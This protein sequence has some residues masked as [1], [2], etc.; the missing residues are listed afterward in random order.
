MDRAN[1][2][3][4][5]PKELQEGKNTNVPPM[6]TTRIC[7]SICAAYIY[8]FI[9]FIYLLAETLIPTESFILYILFEN[10]ANFETYRHRSPCPNCQ[11]A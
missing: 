10:I 8:S 6:E 7:F 2:S 11:S 4:H 3:A 9:L 5:T 1:A